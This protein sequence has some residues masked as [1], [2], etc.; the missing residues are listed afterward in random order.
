MLKKWLRKNKKKLTK[1]YPKK[2]KVV[3]GKPDWYDDYEKNAIE[4][5]K[6]VKKQTYEQV[7]LDELDDFFNSKK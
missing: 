6:E 1:T 4:S 5:S 2:E 7:S 3:K